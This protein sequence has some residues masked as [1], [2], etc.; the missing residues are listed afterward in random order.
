MAYILIG[1][2]QDVGMA[3]A[4]QIGAITQAVVYMVSTRDVGPIA[5]QRIGSFRYVVVVLLA[6]QVCMLLAIARDGVRNP[7]LWLGSVGVLVLLLWSGAGWYR[8]FTA[9]SVT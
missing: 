9:K 3:I 1:H 8:P 4:L 5:R 2:Y 7:G 6:P